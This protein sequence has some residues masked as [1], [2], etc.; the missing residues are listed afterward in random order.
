M[1]HVVLEFIIFLSSDTSSMFRLAHSMLPCPRAPKG[2]SRSAPAVQRA[3]RSGKR[4]SDTD[5]PIN[6][7]QNDSTTMPQGSMRK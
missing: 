7:F 4:V 6:N 2:W 3:Q 1:I 5:P